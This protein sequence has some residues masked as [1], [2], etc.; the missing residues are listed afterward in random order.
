MRQKE[1]LTISLCAAIVVTSALYVLDPRA[2]IYYPVER[3]WRW[4]P[5]PGVAMRWYGRSMVALGGGALAL[6]VALPLLRK[7]GA[8]WD[9]G[10]PAWLYRLLAAVTLLAL[11]GALGHTVAHEYGTWMAGR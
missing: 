4:D 11:V 5:L 9:A 6:A 10:P 7:L 2:P 8:G 1:A 3:V